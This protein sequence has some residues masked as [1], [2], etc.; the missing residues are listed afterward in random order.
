[1]ADDE[2]WGSSGDEGQPSRS[3][4]SDVRSFKMRVAAN[5]EASASLDVAKQK[6]KTKP[7]ITLKMKIKPKAKT[8]E[9]MST[10]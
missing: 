7:K 8:E 10:C 6:K 3:T 9:E 1:M 4:T 5:P 2:L